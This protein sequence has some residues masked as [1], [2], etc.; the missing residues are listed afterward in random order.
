MNIR[1]FEGGTPGAVWRMAVNSIKTNGQKVITE[2]GQ[3]TREIDNMYCRIEHPM[4]GWPISGSN[5][6]L[7]ALEVYYQDEI[8]SKENKSGFDY[9]YGE[10]L[11]HFREP[12]RWEDYYH[13]QVKIV[14]EKLKANRMT[15]RAVASTWDIVTDND[16]DFHPPCLMVVDFLIRNEALHLT[17]FFRSHDFGQAWV[18]N[19]YGL[20]RLQ[21]YIAKEVGAEVG[22][23]S[24]F[25]TSAHIYLNPGDE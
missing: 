5:W 12:D 24:T 18:E 14:I 21:D 1:H 22:S 2:D 9:T 3:E 8:I 10:R 16:E 11:R 13:D 15:R 4:I 20:W 17:A 7:P 6:K 23:L 25:S 19:V